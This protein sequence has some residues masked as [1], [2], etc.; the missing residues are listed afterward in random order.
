MTLPEA[1]LRL[2]R[3]AYVPTTTTGKDILTLVSFDSSTVYLA[4]TKNMI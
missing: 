3:A 1:V 4:N 2:L